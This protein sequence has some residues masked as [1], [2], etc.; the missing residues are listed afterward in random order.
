MVRMGWLRKLERTT[1]VVHM[2]SGQTIRGILTGEYRDC[3]VLN[4]ST[5]LSSLDGNTVETAIDGETIV[6]RENVA[7]LQGLGVTE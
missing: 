1:V 5:Y 6:L 7:W 2:R 4:H 3:L